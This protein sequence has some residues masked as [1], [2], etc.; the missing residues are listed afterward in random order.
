MA[1]RAPWWPSTRQIS[2]P[3]PVAPPVTNATEPL[4]R[5]ERNG[6]CGRSRHRSTVAF[7]EE[8]DQGVV[9]H[10]GLLL[11][12]PVTRSLHPDRFTEVRDVRTRREHRLRRLAEDRVV[13]RTDEE[14][15]LHDRQPGER[16]QQLAGAVDAPVPVQAAEERAVV[17]ERVDE[18][19][20]V[21]VGQPVER[22]RRLGEDVEDSLRG[23]VEEAVLVARDVAR[24]RVQEAA[25]RSDEGRR[26][27][28][29]RRRPAPG[30]RGRRGSCRRARRAC[31]SVG[32]IDGVGR[33][34]IPPQCTLRAATASKRSGRSNAACHATG[35]A[36][37]VADHRGALDAERVEQPDQV[38]DQVELGVLPHLRRACRSARSRAGRARSRGS[39]PRRG[40]RAGGATSTSTRGSRG[41]GRPHG[42]RRVPPRRCAW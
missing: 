24:E 30:S 40:R 6:D 4:R 42:R 31:A 16:R 32:F 2:F 35:A 38:A 28:R 37:V 10:R 8:F 21:V 25:E 19:V 15:G 3:I 41:T 7:V 1:M 17:R 27:A 20:E 11:L 9:D 29:T 39:P 22:A 23:R 34:A 33:G 18:H 13:L 5:S 26:R 36:P 14:R 12:D